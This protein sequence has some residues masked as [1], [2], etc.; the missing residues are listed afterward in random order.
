MLLTAGQD[1]TVCAGA[2]VLLQSPELLK[3]LL[4]PGLHAWCVGECLLLAVFLTPL[5][6]TSGWGGEAGSKG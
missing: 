1:E 6:L 4:V 5:G 3:T 2:C